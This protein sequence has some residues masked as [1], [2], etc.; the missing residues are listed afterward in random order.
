VAS[1]VA[2]TAL[3][4]RLISYIQLV[5]LCWAPQ[6]FGLFHLTPVGP[7]VLSVVFLFS[8]WYWLSTF[9]AEAALGQRIW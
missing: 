8:D 7:Q 3:A 4:L 1:E 6:R 9:A 5:S 2:C